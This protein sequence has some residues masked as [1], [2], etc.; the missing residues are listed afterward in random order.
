MLSANQDENENI[1]QQE[2][3]QDMENTSSSKEQLSEGATKYYA[4]LPKTKD[5]EVDLKK[6]D[7]G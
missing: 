2:T 5:E 7:G 1:M 6:D 3:G 4:R